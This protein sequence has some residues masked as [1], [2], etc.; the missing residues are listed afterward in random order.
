MFVS[1]RVERPLGAWWH[2]GA[3]PTLEVLLHDGVWQAI[4]YCPTAG[5]GCGNLHSILSAGMAG[6]T[7]QQ[8]CPRSADPEKAH[9]DMA[10]WIS[11]CAAWE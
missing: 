8:G 4:G 5:E 9:I 11:L 1:G 7:H 6:V 3:L 2:D 10:R